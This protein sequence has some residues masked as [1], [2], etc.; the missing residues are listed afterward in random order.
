MTPTLVF[1]IVE[2]AVSLAKA[3][4]GGKVQQDA[5]Q[6]GILLQIIQ[7]AVQAYQEHTGEVL[8][9]SLIRAEDGI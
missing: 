7:K 6:A 4:A 1:Q 8:D 5:T 3:Q 9:V 2:L